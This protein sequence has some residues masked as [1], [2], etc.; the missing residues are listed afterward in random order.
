MTETVKLPDPLH[1]ISKKETWGKRAQEIKEL[2]RKEIY[3]SVPSIDYRISTKTLI[4]KQQKAT[5]YRRRLL[6]STISANGKDLIFQTLLY[7]PCR[8]TSPLFVGLNFNGNHTVCSDPDIPIPK[9]TSSKY[10]REVQFSPVYRGSYCSRWP[11]QRILE[12]GYGVAT[13]YARDFDPDYD[14]RFINGVHCFVKRSPGQWGTISAWAWGMSRIMDVLVDREG[15]DNERIASI[16][17][18]RMGKTALWAAAQDKRFSMAISNNSGCGG[19]AL[20]REKKGV[21]ISDITDA[22]PH[23]FCEPFFKYRDSHDKLP[24]DQ[25]WLLSLIAPRPLYVASAAEDAW[26]DP[27]NEYQSLLHVCPVYKMMGLEVIESLEQPEINSPVMTKAMAYHIREGHHN[28]TPWDWE[29][30]MDFRDEA[31]S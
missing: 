28:I 25:H 31:G 12:R 22:F 15:V 18:S 3:G 2:Y 5:G 1:G 8:E 11:V 19:A 9:K 14:D 4:D 10:V 17:H 24:L 20:F 6:E 7:T 26:A 23:W 13:V 29:R 21:S 16:G 30:Y 27:A